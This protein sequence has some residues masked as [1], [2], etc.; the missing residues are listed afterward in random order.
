MRSCKSF[1]QRRQDSLEMWRVFA[2]MGKPAPRW[3]ARR[4]YF[5]FMFWPCLCTTRMIYN[6]LSDPWVHLG[7]LHH[8]RPLHTAPL[9]SGK[10]GWA[11]AGTGHVSLCPQKTQ[12]ETKVFL[13]TVVWS[14][15]VNDCLM[16]LRFLSCFLFFVISTDSNSILTR[17]KE[18]TTKQLSTLKVMSLKWLTGM[19]IWCEQLN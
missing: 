18:T 1:R 7:F 11:L 2:G 19:N 4:M 9:S 5:R 3:Y 13:P 12:S 14:R 16:G 15:W 8:H 10:C 6:H 17:R